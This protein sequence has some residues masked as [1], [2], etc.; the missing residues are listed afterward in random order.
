MATITYDSRTETS[1]ANLSWYERTVKKLEFC[2]FSFISMVILIGSCWGALAAMAIL[3]HDA[4]IWQLEVCIMI[5]MANNVAAIAQAPAKVVFNIAVG[6]AIINAILMA[7]N[8][9]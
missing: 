9:F 6:A 5:S 2:Y 8:V 3:S 4:S 1:E 7:L